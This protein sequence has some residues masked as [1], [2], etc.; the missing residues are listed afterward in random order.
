[1][2][3]IMISKRPTPLTR[4]LSADARKY[5]DMLVC[6]LLAKRAAKFQQWR[7][8]QGYSTVGLANEL[9]PKVHKNTILNW[10]RGTKISHA[11]LKQLV[12]LGFPEKDASYGL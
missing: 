1:M 10:E 6:R 11:Y 12:A 8:L 2:G 3:Y 5:N 7:H 9:K 4:L